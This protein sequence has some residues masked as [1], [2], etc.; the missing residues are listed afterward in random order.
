MALGVA[1]LAG[2]A[3]VAGYYAAPDTAL[4]TAADISNAVQAWVA[5]VLVWVAIAATPRGRTPARLVWA[6]LATAGVAIAVLG[7]LL[8]ITDSSGWVR[9]ALV[10]ILG[11]SLVAPWLAAWCRRTPDPMPMTPWQRDAGTV[12]AVLLGAGVLGIRD[13]LAGTDPDALGGLPGAGLGWPALL[14]IT[15][16]GL[17]F[18]IALPAWATWWG[19]TLLRARGR[20]GDPEVHHHRLRASRNGATRAA[21][22][23][24][25]ERAPTRRWR[26]WDG[27]AG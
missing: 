20:A 1:G 21:R 15:V 12:V 2:L 25:R 4:G 8:I 3:L 5:G 24:R 19:V 26:S 7:S 23:D 17:A 11:W 6:G 22:V 10:H 18:Q 9:A 13:V 27:R 16:G 14:S